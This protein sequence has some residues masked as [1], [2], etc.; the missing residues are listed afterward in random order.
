MIMSLGASGLVKD[1]WPGVA[2]ALPEG[3]KDCHGPQLLFKEK[4]APIRQTED[5]MATFKETPLRGLWEVTPTRHAD[6]RGFL[7]ETF[8]AASC[9]DVG[10]DPTFVQD[11]QS[12]SHRR[13]TLR[14]LHYQAPPHGQAKLVRCGRGRLFDVA[15]DIRGDSPTYGR[16]YGAELTAENGLQLFIPKGFLHG[17]LTLEDNTEI[18]YKCSAAYAPGHDGAVAWNDP[19]IGIDWPVAEADV[20]LSDKDAAAPRLRDIGP[21]FAGMGGVRKDGA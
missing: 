9:R 3:R 1:G 21:V 11:N 18:L 16:W 15:V 19:E 7:A 5:P 20:I 13:H 8:S 6:H 2:W 10:I 4:G 17:F 14:G 12:L